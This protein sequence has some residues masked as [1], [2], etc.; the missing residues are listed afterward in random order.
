MR[1]K[2]PVFVSSTFS[3][4]QPYRLA[5]RDA[6]HRLEA[7]VRGMEYFGALPDMPKSECLRILRGCKIYIGIFAMRYG[8]IDPDKGRSFTHLEYQEAQRLNMP[9]LI[10]LVNEDRQPVLPRNVDFGEHAE[11]LASLKAELKRR[12]VVSFF[13]TPEDL[14]VR[15]SQDLPDLAKRMGSRVRS[16]ELAKLIESLPRINWLTPEVFAFLKREIGTVAEPVGSDDVLKEALEYLLTGDRFTA[17]YLVAQST[18]LGIRRSI[19]LLM[20]IDKKISIVIKHGIQIM[21]EKQKAGN[22]S[23]GSTGGEPVQQ[24]APEGG[25]PAGD[26]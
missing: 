11:K 12:H 1:T 20:Q 25:Q 8:S 16:K 23:G 21:Q 4:L 14:A 7:V 24:A 6:L 17:T 19:D 26:R 18:A 13:T 9:S 22:A 10:Y 15:V 2:L 3:D 5:V